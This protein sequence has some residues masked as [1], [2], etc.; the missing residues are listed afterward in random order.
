[1]SQN[2]SPKPLAGLKVLELTRLLPGPF[3]TRLLADLGAE[4]I[5]VEDPAG[6]DYLRHPP[7]RIGTVSAHFLA[8][9]TGKCSIALDLKN[10]AGREV[11][12]RLLAR[13]D[14]LVESFRPGVMTRLGIDYEQLKAVQPRLIYASL[15]GYG[16]TGPYRDRAGHDLNYLSLAGAAGLTGADD[17][18][19]VVSGMQ[20]ADLSGALYLAIAILSAVYRREQTGQG[21]QVDLAMADSSLAL[22]ALP[23]AEYIGHNRLPGPARMIVNGKF[24]CYRIYRTR[25]G[26]FMSLAALEPKFWVAF[27]RAVE[28]PHLCDEA[29]TRAKPG[30]P[31]FDEL[32]AL[33]ASKDQAEWVAALENADCCCEPVLTL[34]EAA[35]HPQFAARRGFRRIDD[36]AQGS[37]TQLNQ[38]IRFTPPVDD[39]TTP[40]PALG[41]HTSMILRE[42]GLGETEIEALAARGAF[43]DIPP[44]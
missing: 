12:R 37:Y 41:E 29:Y 22:L 10:E 28:K 13:Y 15:T 7:P 9:N 20:V 17:G 32:V 24:V 18:T 25:D 31:V 8:N 16:Q 33:F 11:L 34:A 36:P 42:A 23:F 30:N 6:G 44:Q 14:I 27:C 38:P 4:V 40:S 2:A 19:P 5:K 3:A 1:M 43:G 26:R 35:A 21:C 39:S